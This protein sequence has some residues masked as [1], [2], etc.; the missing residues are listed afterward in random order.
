MFGPIGREILAFGTCCFAIFACGG[1]LLAGQI[2]LASL[3]DNKL[4]LM[5]YTGIFAIPMLL[6][7][8]PR[9]FHGLS[10]ISIISVLS[11]FI[12]GVVGMAA[13]GISPDPD[14]SID[15]AVPS[16]FYVAFTSITNPVFSYAGHFM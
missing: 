14:R 16:N 5:L 15:V 4:C 8:L 12:A 9:T 2:A 7:S 10:W 11:I 6:C 13:A 1:Q 3:S